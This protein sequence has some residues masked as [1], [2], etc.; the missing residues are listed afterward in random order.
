MDRAKSD[1]FD[2]PDPRGDQ[3]TRLA[4]A[5][6]LNRTRATAAS[7][8]K[9]LLCG[10]TAQA[11]GLLARVFRMRGMKRV[12]VENPGFSEQCT[13]LRASGIETVAVPVDEEGIQ[14][15]ALRRLKV[16]AVFVAPAHQYPTG[17]V[18]SGARRTE[19]LDWAHQTKGFVVEDDY[20]AEY[21]YDREPIGALHGLAPDLTIY[22]GTVSKTLAPALR[23]GWV[24]LPDS[25]MED[26]ARAKHLADRG[27]PVPEQLALASFI[28]SGEMDRHIRRTRVIYKRRRDALVAAL[29]RFLPHVKIRGISAGLHLLAELEDHTDEQQIIQ[30]AGQ[31]GIRVFGVGQY[32]IGSQACPAALVL[33]YG[34]LQEERI[35][36]AVRRL[37]EAVGESAQWKRREPK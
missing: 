17:A 7:P 22:T 15:H 9:L 20:D 11:V 6:Y 32:A 36:L 5:S 25:L 24:L 34:A 12:A 29:R 10:G 26:V 27:S 4:L 8:N 37:A 21:R 31:D 14:V 19:L 16:G 3:S 35:P 18:L 13:D 28:N 23:L 30:R 33:G 1:V 2:Y